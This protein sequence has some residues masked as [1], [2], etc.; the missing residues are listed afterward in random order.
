MKIVHLSSADISGGAA[1]AAFRLHKGLQRAGDE[2]SMFV[3]T[4][5]SEDASV[6]CY[7]APT[8]AFFQAQRRVRGLRIRADFAMYRRSRPVGYEAFSDDRT[9]FG[10]KILSQLPACDIINLHWIAG[11]VDYKGMMGAMT[12][13]APVVWRLADMNAFTGGCHYDED[14]RRFTTGC[15]RCPQLGSSEQQDLSHRIWKRKKEAFDGLDR[16]RLHIVTL[17]RWM[18]DQVKE[19]PLLSRFPVTLIPNGVDLDS[20]APRDRVFARSVLG[21]PADARVAMFVSD[22]LTNR[23]KGFSLLLDALAGMNKYSHL[24][25]VSV[26]KG[27]PPP[28]GDV[29]C[30]HLGHVNNDRWL[31]LIYSAADVF[32]IPSLQDNLPNTVLEAMACGIPVVGFA[33]GGISDMVRD[34]ATGL[35][36]RVGD[37]DG[38]RNALSEL[39]ADSLTRDSMGNNGRRVAEQEYSRDRQIA[40]YRDLYSSL[41]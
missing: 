34:G 13:R 17:C 29:P 41:R 16:T 3:A 20:F 18:S 22:D 40:R 23:R 27:R 36:L 21:I 26:G 15:G 39:L 5:A 2:S 38:L 28:T 4:K 11:L 8:G 12:E 7:R 6:A 14:C 1:L 32:V 33:A 25:L 30:L 24:F 35:L 31:S 10:H 19:S 9:R 37:V